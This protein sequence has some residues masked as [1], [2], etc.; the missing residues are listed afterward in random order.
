MD[1]LI[2]QAHEQGQTARASLI[3]KRANE[4]FYDQFATDVT[5]VWLGYE[6]NLGKVRY[7]GKEYLA[8]VLSATGMPIGRR[9]NL[10]RTKN[11]NFVTW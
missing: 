9:V 5:G 3:E 4:D 7:K 8:H 1:D 2:S 6:G 10:R 11:R